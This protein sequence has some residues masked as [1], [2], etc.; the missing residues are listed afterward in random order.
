MKSGSRCGGGL[1]DPL[2]A[3]PL[4]SKNVMKRPQKRRGGVVLELSRHGDG[5]MAADA[6]QPGPD[7]A[8]E[9]SVLRCKLCARTSECTSTDQIRYARNGWPRC[10]GQVMELFIQTPPD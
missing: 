6:Q 2:S 9:M 1:V 8:R 3:L 4:K 5:T 10:C 7:P